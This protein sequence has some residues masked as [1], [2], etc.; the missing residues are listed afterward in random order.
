LIVISPFSKKNYVSHT[1]FDSTA[2][3]KLIQT[4]FNVPAL[5]KPDAAQADMGEFFDFVGVPWA[6][7]PTPLAQVTGGQCTLN[8]PTP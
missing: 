3:L 4:R 5:T 6:S 2:I 1:V 8:P 7:P